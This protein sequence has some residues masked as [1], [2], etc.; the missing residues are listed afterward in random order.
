MSV[1]FKLSGVDVTIPDEMICMELALFTLVLSCVSVSGTVVLSSN[2]LDNRARVIDLRKH[3]LKDVLIKHVKRE[4]S[5]REASTTKG[6]KDHAPDIHP[7]TL[8]DKNHNEAI[9]H[10]SGNKSNVSN[11]T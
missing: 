4:R 10:W 1:L 2:Q 5:K 11:C 6:D 7:L 3:D 9:V 8:P